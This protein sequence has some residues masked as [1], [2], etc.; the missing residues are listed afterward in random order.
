[1]KI[2]LAPDSFKGS[3]TSIEIIDYLERAA[4][5][6]FNP[7]EIVKVPIADGGEGTVDA[8]TV[9]KG[10]EYRWVEVTGPLGEKVKAKY[11]IIEDKTAVIEMAQASGLPLIAPCDRNPLLTTTYGTG[12]IIKAALDEGIREF[13][14]GIGGSATNDG[15]IGA[16][17]A[18]GIRFLDSKGNEVGFGGRELSRIKHINME[19]LDPRIKESSIVVICDVNNPLTGD[20]GATAVFG[21]QK[22]ATEDMLLVL[23]KGMKNYAEVIRTQLG[24]DVD[25]IPGS[26]AAG[27]LGAAFIC[28]LGAELKPGIDTILDFANFEQLLTDVDLVITGE[29][30]IDGQSLFGKVPVGIARRCKKHGVKVVVIAGSMGDGAQAVYEYGIE[31]IM[32]IINKDMSLEEAISRSKELLM[33]AADRMFRLIK[34]G[35]QLRN[36]DND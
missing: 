24:I 33:D 36:T 7:I 14:I 20:K 2:L 35:M 27:G 26:G 25:R 8:L 28:F 1:M 30:R 31:S 18:L 23:E 29:G 12:E 15:G 13:I 21:P 32:T 9:L 16:A 5:Q 17:Q 22:G 6:N 3:M 4:R 34:L 10:G 11:G 19:N